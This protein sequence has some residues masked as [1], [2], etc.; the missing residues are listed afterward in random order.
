MKSLK[1]GMLFAV[2]IA[3][4]TGL[5]AD[6]TL[7]AALTTVV[8]DSKVSNASAI[9]DET[10]NAVHTVS[11][12]G[13]GVLI[14]N[15]LTAITNNLK[16]EEKGKLRAVTLEEAYKYIAAAVLN[17]PTESRMK[18]R[19]IASAVVADK[20]LLAAFTGFQL[21][22][23]GFTVFATVSA[24]NGIYGA[25]KVAAFTKKF[26]GENVP[27]AARF[28]MDWAV[29]PVSKATFDT[30]V[31]SPVRWATNPLAS[32]KRHPVQMGVSGAALGTVGAYYG[33]AAIKGRSAARTL[34]DN[35]LEKIP[36]F[37][38]AFVDDVIKAVL[39]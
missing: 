15:L 23:I 8:H 1:N 9:Q 4:V 13:F 29:V 6:D 2:A 14:G 27:A 39:R 38:P 10:G 17:L 24:R 34:R 37:V 16:I 30:V 19:A 31:T 18:F 21:T 20:K 22:V 35:A 33:Y 36:N 32:L 11:Q 12:A 25:D 28:V 7:A 26:F 3:S 5:R